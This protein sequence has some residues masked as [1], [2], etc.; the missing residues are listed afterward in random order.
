MAVSPDDSDFTPPTTKKMQGARALLTVASLFVVIAGLRVAAP[1]LVPVAVAFFL[2]VL[3]YPVMAWLMRKRV[4]HVVALILTVG[5]IVVVL[6]LLGWAGY[7]LLKNFAS[8][9]PSYLVRL[10]GIV[11]NTAAWL[12]VRGWVPGAVKAVG[13]FNLQSL[14][15]LATSQ[16]VMKQLFGYAGATF[17]TIAIFLG[18]LI[19]V[20]V[21]LIFVLLEAP[22]THSRV[23]LMRQTGGPDLRLLLNS[24]TDIQ[25]YLGVKTLISAATGVSAYIW[26]LIFGLKFPMLWGIVAFLFNYIP[27]VG[28][29]IAALP[30]IAEG[31]VTSGPGCAIGVA[32]GYG[33][34]NL[35]LDSFLQ[36]LLMGRRFGMSGL[37][38]M[39]SVV[40]WGWLWGPIGMFLAVPLTIMIKVLLENTQE[41]RWV[42]AAMAK[43][44]VKRGEI[45]LETSDTMDAEMLGS[46]AA[47]EPPRSG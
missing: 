9:M 21:V 31:L 2:A 15:D 7:G 20:L 33:I 23:E 11:D 30:A 19:G 14:I 18:S 5:S 35:C 25:K 29:T 1:F 13:E 41:F 28:S 24:A 22:G 42:S 6:G 47:T 43:K 39:L 12:E 45:V 16:D 37:V 4:P 34:I 44:K 3:S 36:P 27:A 10:K 32:I 17:G 40:F 46:G 26:C 8:E 38:I